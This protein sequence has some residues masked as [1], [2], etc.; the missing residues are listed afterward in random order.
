MLDP[1]FVSIAVVEGIEDLR[2]QQCRA[3]S[4]HLVC[5][6]HERLRRLLRLLHT[7]RL[8]RGPFRLLHLEPVRGSLSE[9][10][11]CSNGL[12]GGLESAPS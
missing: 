8:L 1:G 12:W 9:F 11:P 4:W 5:L 2:I 7:G 10:H 3:G 6:R